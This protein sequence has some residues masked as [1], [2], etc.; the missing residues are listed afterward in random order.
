MLK[1]YGFGHGYGFCMH[2]LISRKL[3]GVK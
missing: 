3:G 2:H 1:D